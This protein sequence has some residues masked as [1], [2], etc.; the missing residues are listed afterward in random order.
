MGSSIAYFLASN[1]DYDGSIAVVEKDF[2]YSA[3]ATTRSVGS[4]RQQFST[5]E[6]VLISQ[7]GY[8]FLSNAHEFLKVGDDSPDISLFRSAY[9]LLATHAGQDELRRGHDVQTGCGTQVEYLDAASLAR[10][11]HW[12]NVEDLAAGCRGLQGEGWF[13]PYSLLIALKKKAIS[14][15]VRYIEDEVIHVH[16][17]SNR[18]TG[19]DLKSYGHLRCQSIVNAAGPYAGDLALQAGISLPVSPRRRNVFVF[20]SRARIEDMPLLVDPAGFYV[21]PEGEYYLCGYSP[22]IHEE[23]PIDYTLDVDH[24]LFDD[25]IWPKLAHRIPQFETLR[26]ANSW[27]GHYDYNSFDQNGIVGVHP[28]F[29]NYYFANGFSGH[30]LQQAPAIGRAISELLVDGQ[31]KSLDLT[32]LGY[33][34]ILAEQK[35]GE[36]V[37]I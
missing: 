24:E 5:P 36:S 22:P 27:A 35:Y 17:K 11:F 13:D 14:L 25:L 12:L 16:L 34:R 29:S 7:F 10:T 3:C 33:E 18:I 21:R 1:S 6:N 19:A 31:Y 30:G 28:E 8:Q 15:G 4:I 32:R 20:H 9:L 23:D 26:V 37:I 2:T